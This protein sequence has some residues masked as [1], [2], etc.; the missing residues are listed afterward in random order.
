MQ[1]TITT[2]KVILYVHQY[3][4]FFSNPSLKQK[5]KAAWSKARSRGSMDDMCAVRS[6]VL[7]SISS[8]PGKIKKEHPPTKTSLSLSPSL[9]V[10]VCVSLILT[11]SRTASC[12]HVHP[13]M[14]THPYLTV[15][16]LQYLFPFF[17]LPS[18][19]FPFKSLLI[20]RSS[21]FSA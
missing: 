9:S 12:Q 3:C 7:D 11:W 10:C 20:T 4:S 14:S 17:P 6:Q 2:K 15:V 5:S 13:K 19:P 18:L 8:S 16:P 21:L 1:K